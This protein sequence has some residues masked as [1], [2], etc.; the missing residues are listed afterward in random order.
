ME[1]IELP[2]RDKLWQGIGVSH[3]DQGDEE[4]RISTGSTG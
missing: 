4:K 3:R 2:K 1:R